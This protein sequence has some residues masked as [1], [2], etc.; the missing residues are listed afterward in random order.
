M[1]RCVQCDTELVAPVRS[2]YWSDKH[3]CHIWH[4]PKCCACF[5]S[6]VSFFDEIDA[7]PVLHASTLCATAITASARSRNG[8]GIVMPSAFVRSLRG[9]FV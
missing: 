1:M 2:E 9:S 3:A 7:E 6:L 8:S 4:C 5:S